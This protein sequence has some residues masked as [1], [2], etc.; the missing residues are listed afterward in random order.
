MPTLEFKR[1]RRECGYND[2][3]KKEGRGR[4]IYDFHVLID[5]EHR[6]TVKPLFTR[7]GYD[8]FDIDGRPILGQRRNHGRTRLFMGQLVEFFLTKAEMEP[9]IRLLL[10]EGA[11]PTLA[12]MV[13]KR[14]REA[15]A[16]E[17]A[18]H[19]G[20]EHMKLQAVMQAGPD[21]Y[22]ALAPLVAYLR[23]NGGDEAYH[24]ADGT[25]WL[26]RAETAMRKAEGFPERP[27]NVERVA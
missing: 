14:Q 26:S 16:Q 8:V 2:Q 15:E 20:R 17:R 23:N 22:A 27:K 9:R 7:R 6:A 1:T 5:G 19:E 18:E 13:E 21:L 10:E 4:S 24:D 25:G 3:V 12:E 11:I